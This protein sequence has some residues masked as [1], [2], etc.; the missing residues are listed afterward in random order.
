MTSALGVVSGVVSGIRV[1]CRGVVITGANRGLR[2]A[3]AE[4]LA[5]RGWFVL[6]GHRRPAAADSLVDSVVAR[7]GRAVGVLLDVTDPAAG[8]QPPSGSPTAPAAPWTP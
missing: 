3:T 2:R 8:G 4:L 6:A 5:A 1:S 7:G